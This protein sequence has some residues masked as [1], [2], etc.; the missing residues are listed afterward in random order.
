MVETGGNTIPP[1]RSLKICGIISPIANG[2]KKTHAIRLQGQ[3]DLM[4]DFGRFGSY[5][6]AQSIELRHM[7]VAYRAQI[8]LL[9]A[10]CDVEVDRF[11]SR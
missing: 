11:F 1:T 9:A 2:T 3:M 7:Q 6:L 5:W 4:S 10:D 8:R